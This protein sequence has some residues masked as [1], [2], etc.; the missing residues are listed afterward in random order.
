[1]AWET[2]APACPGGAPRN[3][4]S[5]IW[6]CGRTESR[7][8]SGPGRW[9]GR[10]QRAGH[11]AGLPGGGQVPDGCGSVRHLAYVGRVL[12]GGKSRHRSGE[13]CRQQ[14]RQGPP[15]RRAATMAAPASFPSNSELSSPRKRGPSVFRLTQR[16]WVPAFAGM[17]SRGAV[18]QSRALTATLFSRQGSPPPL[19][20][21]PRTRRR[22]RRC[23]PA[24]AS[25]APAAAPSPGPGPRRGTSSRRNAG[26]APARPRGAGG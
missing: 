12:W 9:I 18:P 5:R 7:F 6:R 13:P 3:A 17:T 11:Y 14:P 21:A 20:R 16:R 19:S 1:M 25:P 24:P 4:G 8:R 15:R 10:T 26:P 2:A 23:T 22:P